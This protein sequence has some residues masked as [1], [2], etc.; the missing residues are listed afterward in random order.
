[1]T[2]SYGLITGILFGVLLQRA[3]MLRFDRQVGALLFRDMTIV[4]FM[5]TAILVAMVGMYLLAD[6]GFAKFA[7]KETELVGNVVGGLLFGAGWAILG[8]CPGTAAGALGEGRWDALW[9]ILGG[10]AGGALYAEVYPWLK[11]NLLPI[12]NYGKV[13]LP[14][15]VGGSPWLV[16]VPV[17][18]GGIALLLWLE[19]RGL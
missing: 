9:G 3:Q 14:L 18:A 11:L 8:Y 2:L 19:R 12:G 7:I 10:L 6:L 15:L 16:V 17:V 13:T 1:M 4:K 5:V